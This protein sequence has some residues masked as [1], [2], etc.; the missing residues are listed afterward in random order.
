M[1]LGGLVGFHQ[2]EFRIKREFQAKKQVVQVECLSHDQDTTI[3][4]QVLGLQNRVHK[5]ES[6]CRLPALDHCGTSLKLASVSSTAML[7]SAKIR[8]LQM[9]YPH[10]LFPMP[11]LQISPPAKLLLAWGTGRVLA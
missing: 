11:L 8:E 10:V 2:A 9:A 7:A 5:H 6:A 1:G 3:L 4:L